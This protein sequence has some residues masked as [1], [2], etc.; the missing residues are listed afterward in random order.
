MPAS[1]YIH[2]TVAPVL[3]HALTWAA[4]SLTHLRDTNSVA[5][6]E[7]FLRSSPWRYS[8]GQE[9]MFVG[10]ELAWLTVLGVILFNESR[11]DDD[12]A[13]GVLY[14]DLSTIGK[15][16]RNYLW[17]LRDLHAYPGTGPSAKY[18]VAASRPAYLF[19]LCSSEESLVELLA[20]VLRL[21]RDNTYRFHCPH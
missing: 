18:A 12:D 3:P 20:L 1:D 13:Y 17:H 8:D 19:S 21:V 5:A 6:V 2:R 4:P 7:A 16:F 10:I 15:N 9:D 14:S 11:P